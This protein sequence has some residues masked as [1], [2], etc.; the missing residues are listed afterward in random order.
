MFKPRVCILRSAGTN[1]DAETAFAF[2][3]LGC[4]TELVHVN[5]LVEGKKSLAEFHILA[6]PGGFTYGDD[7]AAGKVLANEL[8]FKLTRPLREFITA[9]KLVIGICNGFQILVKSGF[10]PGSESLE[11]EAS[12]IINDSGSFQDRWVYLKPEKPAGSRAGKQA[13][14][15]WTKDLPPVIYLPIAHGEGKFVVRDETV[16]KR[17]TQNGQVVFRYCTQ[18]GEL[19][20]ANPNGSIGNIAGICD[21]TGRVLGLMPHPERHMGPMQHP[22]WELSRDPARKGQK[23][24]DGFFIIWNGVEYVRK[25]FGR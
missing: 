23:A 19:K 7:I 12:L 5:K 22:R 14:C 18:E 1:C 16:L 25:V 11:Q 9:G 21:P 20:G 3:S 4:E 2:S 8:R 17:L 10:L 6:L 24:G 15:V 13:E